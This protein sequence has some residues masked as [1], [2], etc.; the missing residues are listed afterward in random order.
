[1]NMVIVASNLVGYSHSASV[2]PAERYDRLGAVVV[3]FVVEIIHAISVTSV[4]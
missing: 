1:M 2:N 3:C 4:A